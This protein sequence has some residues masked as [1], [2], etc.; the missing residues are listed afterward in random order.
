MDARVEDP[1]TE[2]SLT[3]HVNRL[4]FCVPRLRDELAQEPFVPF[5]V[6][7][8][9]L[10]NSYLHELLGEGLLERHSLP[11]ATQLHGTSPTAGSLDFLDQPR[12]KDKRIFRRNRDPNML[13]YPCHVQS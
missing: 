8:G 6:P 7:N 4:V 2:G 12:A 11:T 1:E 13:I 9:S 3:V 5:D 10:S